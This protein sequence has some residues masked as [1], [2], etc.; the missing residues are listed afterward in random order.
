MNDI[1]ILIVEDESIVAMEIG[2]YLQILDYT[3]VG[4]CSSAQEALDTIAK[5][6]VDIVLMDIFL[7][8]VHDGIETAEYIKKATRISKSYF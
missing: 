6:E 3:I 2:S 5:K 7:K 1:K 8:G 4:I